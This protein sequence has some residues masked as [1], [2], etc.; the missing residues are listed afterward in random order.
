MDIDVNLH[1]RLTPPENVYEGNN[2]GLKYFKGEMDLNCLMLQYVATVFSKISGC[3]PYL[4]YRYCWNFI[5]S[6]VHRL[7]MCMKENHIGLKYFR[8]WI[9]M[10]VGYPLVGWLPVLCNTLRMANPIHAVL[11]SLLFQTRITKVLV[12][13]F[14]YITKLDLHKST[15]ESGVLT[16]LCFSN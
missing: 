13:F 7:G 11:C 9:G 6:A 5:S 4:L 10:G 14:T 15:G 2:P 3:S 16:Y 8:R 1:S 12:I